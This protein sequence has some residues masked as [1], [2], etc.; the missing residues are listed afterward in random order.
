MDVEGVWKSVVRGRIMM[1]G[2]TG[3][4]GSAFYEGWL[5]SS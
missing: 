2:R 1:G 3:A 4:D 5:L